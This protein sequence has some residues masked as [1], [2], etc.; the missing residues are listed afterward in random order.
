[1]SGTWNTKYGTRRV[2]HDPP[3]LEEAIT[4]ARGLTDDVEEQVDFAASLMG[5]PLDEVRA[6]VLKTASPRNKPAD[7]IAFTGRAGNQR[8]VIVERKPTRRVAAV[9]TASA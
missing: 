3:T 6:E 2:R 5:L 8:T 4:A 1:M 9:R 7:T